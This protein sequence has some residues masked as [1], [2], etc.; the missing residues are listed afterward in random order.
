MTLDGV[1]LRR[2]P[3]AAAEAVATL[4][5]GDRIE[6]FGTRGTWLEVESDAGA[7]GYLPVDVVERASDRDA[8]RRREKTLLDFTPVYGVVGE[9]TDVIL[10]PYPL[11]ARA[12]R[13]AKGSGHRDPLGRSLLLRVQGQDVGH[14]VR[15][16]GRG[17]PD[18]AGSARARDRA[19]EGQAS[20]EPHGH[21]PGR[22]AAA[23]RGAARRRSP[24]KTPPPSRARSRRPPDRLRPPPAPA[25][26]VL[27]GATLVKRV[28]PVY[29]DLA[30]RAGI[31]GTVELEVSIDA[32]GAVTDV[33]VV[34]G[35]PLGMSEA[36][37]DA[38]HRWKY[39]PARTASGPVASRKSVRIR[40][41]LQAD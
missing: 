1:E 20:Q 22:R 11:A 41:V 26:G 33:E 16:L 31:E 15:Q 23:R 28:D 2:E 5:A 10:A 27:E 35:L 19:R 6:A 14:R 36:A 40:F 34:R 13:L 30:R 24:G 3:S 39:K 37:A 38:V 4:S 17:G 8:R 7:R 25:A 9:A 29:P 32:T 21:R 12:G 18:P